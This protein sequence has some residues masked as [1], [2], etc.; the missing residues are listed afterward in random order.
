VPGV[1]AAIC[2]KNPK[3]GAAE[4]LTAFVVFDP[5]VRRDECCEAIRQ[6][7][8]D[9][10]GILL[11]MGNIHAID[12]IPRNENGKPL[13]AV[14]QKMILDGAAAMAA[15]AAADAAMAQP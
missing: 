3:A 4:Q 13:R 6:A 11:S 10:F 14:A 8:S 2:V 1:A 15:K 12:K 9:R 7:V 5:L